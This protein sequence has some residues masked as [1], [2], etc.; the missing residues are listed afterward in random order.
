MLRLLAFL[1]SGC[2]HKWEILKESDVYEKG[3]TGQLNA[4]PFARDYYLH[5]ERCGDVKSRR[6]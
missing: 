3:R 5:C 2:W 4:L 1:W 6:L